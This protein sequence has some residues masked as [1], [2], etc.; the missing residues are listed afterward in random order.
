MD[1][2]DDDIV[3]VFGVEGAD[4]G[5]MGR[6]IDPVSGEYR[7]VVHTD[8]VDGDLFLHLLDAVRP[9]ARREP[10]NAV[11][12]VLD[13]GLLRDHP[14]LRG[15]ILDE[16]D[17]TG[18]GPEDL[19]GHGTLVALLLIDDT[20]DFV[21]RGILNL[22]ISDANGRGSPQNLIAGLDWLVAYKQEHPD[23]RVTANI[24][25]GVYRRRLLNLLPCN[26]TCDVCEAALRAAD[27]DILITAA[28]GN[29][30]GKTACP[31]TLAIHRDDLGV[32]AVT[33]P[34]G[35]HGVGSIAAPSRFES[36]PLGDAS[37]EQ[38]STGLG[39]DRASSYM[40]ELGSQLEDQ[41]DVEQ[42][43][44]TFRHLA[45]YG[46]GEIWQMRGHAALGVLLAESGRL[47]EAEHDLLLVAES[48]ASDRNDRARCQYTLGHVYRAAGRLEEAR[49][50]LERAVASEHEYFAPVAA[51]FLATLDLQN[52]DYVRA[53]PHLDLAAESTDLGI[54]ASALYNRG[55]IAK[56][57]GDRAKAIADLERVI[58]MPHDLRHAAALTLAA[59][60]GKESTP[61]SKLLELL[62]LA[63]EA[64]QTATAAGA[65]LALADL[66]AATEQ[67]D[68]A[69]EFYAKAAE[70]QVQGVSDVADERLSLL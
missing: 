46:D 28:A 64:P 56:Q 29:T 1:W 50:T 68:V 38:V 11:M 55:R 40:L 31:A 24:S 22:K 69:R 70:R 62:L 34:S 19:S 49:H 66:A 42:A 44:K 35:E 7:N 41:G 25:A 12:A 45:T 15:R 65:E 54:V 51:H 16:V 30:P 8:A 10:P 53:V 13:T 47:A 63:A 43:E 33:T 26:G 36:H 67:Y 3:E 32:V 27:A 18:E 6:V 52:G 48:Q 37:D 5:F 60:Y 39:G 21:C 61:V 14:S 17:F 23:L 59:L 2:R 20:F 9:E 58:A 4:H 57:R